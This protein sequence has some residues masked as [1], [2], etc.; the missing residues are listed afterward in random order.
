[1]AKQPEIGPGWI[2]LILSSLSG[3]R[4]GSVQI[5]VHDGRI[6]QI[7]RNEKHRFDGSASAAA[8]S[9]PPKSSRK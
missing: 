9:E 4:Y 1:M 5:V 7:E 6:V 8:S 3:L 2:E